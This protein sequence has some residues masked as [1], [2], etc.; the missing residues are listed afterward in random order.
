[1]SRVGRD[2]ATPR[3]QIGEILTVPTGNVHVRQDG[4]VD[5]RPVLLL[6]GFEGSVHW[7]DAVTPL[8]ADTHRVI[9]VDLLGFGCTGGD[10]GFDAS[11]QGRML[12]EVLDQLGVHDAVAVGHSWG[13]DAALAVADLSDRVSAVVIVD[14]APD[15]GDLRLPAG[16]GKV[17][18]DPLVRSFH[19]YAP[20]PVIRAM[21][22]KGFAPGFDVNTSVPGFPQLRRD[23]K[24]M[25]WR[26]IRAVAVDRRHALE[27]R[28]LD[29]RVRAL[30]LPTLAVH[31]GRDQLYPV[32]QV[33][34]RYLGVG[35]EVVV[36]DSAGH[37]PNI[38]APEQLSVA[39][40]EFAARTR[41][42]E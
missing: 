34:A 27:L 19:R 28:P 14:Q 9:R 16:L 33:R 8:L 18:R 17:L 12:T 35:A 25:S 11:S 41:E 4:P 2:N 5:G 3:E 21:I 40:R 39:I 1:M 42:K 32:A 37:S 31:G 7:W 29:V 13:A 30:G 6:H 10:T 38:E 15:Y 24:D 20:N 23:F 22:A 26:T 36:I